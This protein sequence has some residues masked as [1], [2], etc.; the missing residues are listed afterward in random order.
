MKLIDADTLMCKI[1]ELE[2]KNPIEFT[3]ANV[4]QCIAEAPSVERHG[5]WKDGLCCSICDAERP[6]NKWVFSNS[7]YCYSC[8]AKMDGTEEG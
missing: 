1:T 4:K 5:Y 8:G 7:N 3:A 2:L 6:T